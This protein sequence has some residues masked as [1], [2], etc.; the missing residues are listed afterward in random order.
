[1]NNSLPFGIDNITFE[2]IR[3]G[4]L[5]PLED[6]K[7]RNFYQR[8]TDKTSWLKWILKKSYEYTVGWFW[9]TNAV[10]PENTSLVSVSYLN[11]I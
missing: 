10:I 1:M 9:R 6:L 2:L 11:V 5:I 4:H 8:K 3:R 7:S